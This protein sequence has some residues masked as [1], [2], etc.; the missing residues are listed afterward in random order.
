MTRAQAEKFSVNDKKDTKAVADKSAGSA[1]GIER[2]ARAE[3]KKSNA[4]KKHHESDSK[5]QNVKSFKTAKLTASH[6]QPQ[7]STDSNVEIAEVFFFYIH[8]LG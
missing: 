3:S 2:V 7:S 8:Q 5:A 4:F 6:L 1:N